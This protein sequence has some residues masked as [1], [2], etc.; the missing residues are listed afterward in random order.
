[1]FFITIKCNKDLVNAL[2]DLYSKNEVV[3]VFQ[4][5]VKSRE[6]NE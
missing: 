1:M 6:Y 2:S 4:K 3:K 5:C